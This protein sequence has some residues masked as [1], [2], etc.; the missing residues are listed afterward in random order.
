MRLLASIKDKGEK[1][2]KFFYSYIYL[3]ILSLSV[4]LSW[5]LNAPYIGLAAIS[6]LGTLTLL[7]N[8]DL[9][10]T[11]ALIIFAACIFATDDISS[12]LIY[13]TVLIPLI[14][15]IPLHFVIYGFK[16]RIGKMFFP[17]LAISIAIL[18]A[19]VGTIALKNYLSTLFYCILLGF[20]ILLF[21]VL[22]CSFDKDDI[23][24]KKDFFAKMMLFYGML[25]CLQLAS[26]YLTKKI[27]FSEWGK[28]WIHLGWAIDNNL[29]TLL[30]L[31]APYSFYLAS[32]YKNKAWLFTLLGLIQY[33]TICFTFSRG[34]MLFAAVTAPFVIGF[35]IAKSNKKQVLLTLG[36]FLAAALAFYFILFDQINEKVASMLSGIGQS[37]SDF[38]ANRD[39]LYRE[40]IDLF[41]RYP[42]NGAGMGY[43]GSN[44]EIVVI[45]FY[46][47]HSTFFQIIG[48]M[49]AIGLLAYIYFY[50]KRY[51]II[52]RNARKDIF[53]LF[54]LL[55]MI[56]FEL[57]CMVD[58]GTFIPV[59]TMMLAMMLTYMNEKKTELI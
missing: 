36:I 11:M 20:V 23:K 22:F 54:S 50:A 48:S 9:T 15:S 26:Y 14:I 6:I 37:D 5:L 18:V 8:E 40:A 52:V 33:V 49:G 46:W 24:L 1:A 44:Y 2:K 32:Q 47:F 59:P 34:G 58:T 19:G 41:L 42:I 12:Y 51:K 57:Y 45:G 38:L 29:A 30:L 28:E 25:I 13:I 3:F 21:Y 55:A 7:F 35:G 10:P 16:L 39:K 4:Y 53:G 43:A 56:G 31:T 27:P 17:Q